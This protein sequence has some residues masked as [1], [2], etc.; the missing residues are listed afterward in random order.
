MEI[1]RVSIGEG[2]WEVS[3]KTRIP[4][5]RIIIPERGEISRSTDLGEQ[6]FLI[7]FSPSAIYDVIPLPFGAN[8]SVVIYDLEN[9]GWRSVMRSVVARRDHSYSRE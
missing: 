4:K 2:I 1:V 5:R 6:V 9:S 7:P 3:I 8:K